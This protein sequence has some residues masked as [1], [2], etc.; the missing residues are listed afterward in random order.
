MA[1]RP[2]TGSRGVSWCTTMLF[3]GTRAS[4]NRDS[5]PDSGTATLARVLA[6]DDVAVARHGGALH[7][8][9]VV[10]FPRI[11]GA[12]LRAVL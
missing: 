12:P 11:R 10:G 4:T 2:T 3:G 7:C 5:C 8:E 9:D 6:F 1:E